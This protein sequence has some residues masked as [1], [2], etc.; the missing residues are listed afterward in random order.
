MARLKKNKNFDN[1]IKVDTQR[2]SIQ[3]TQKAKW[4]KLKQSPD[5]AQSRGK[6][7]GSNYF[8]RSVC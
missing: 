2:I 7:L 5:V 4:S 3:H 8:I 1:S 6:K